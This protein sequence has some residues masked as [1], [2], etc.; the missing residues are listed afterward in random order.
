VR[1]ECPTSRVWPG[2]RVRVLPGSQL[3]LFRD[4]RYLIDS[5]LALKEIVLGAT[6][7]SLTPARTTTRTCPLCARPGLKV[8]SLCVCPREGYPGRRLS[9]HHVVLYIVHLCLARAIFGPAYGS[10]SAAIGAQPV[11]GTSACD[12]SPDTSTESMLQVDL[13]IRFR[14]QPVLVPACSRNRSEYRQLS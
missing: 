2:N 5:I 10:R 12:Q 3:F 1:R 8:V 7:V 11:L 4:P 6:R 9:W 14:E 13:G